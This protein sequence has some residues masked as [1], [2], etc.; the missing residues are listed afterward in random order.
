[1]VYASGKP[2]SRKKRGEHIVKPSNLLLAVTLAAVAGC[3]EPTI[4]ASTKEAIESSSQRVRDSLPETQQAEFDEAL[5]ILAFSE[6]DVND[7][8]AEG[9]VGSS[10]LEE[11]MRTALD[12]KTASEIIAEADKIVVE[13]KAREREQAM[14]EIKELHLK[15]Q[16]AET[17]RVELEKFEVFRSRFYMQKGDF[18]QNQPIIELSVRNGTDAPISRA[19]FEGTIASPER[20]VPWLKKEFNYSI[21]GGLEP[22]E[23]GTWNLAPNQFSEWGKVDAPTDAIFTVTVERLDGPGG[24]KLYSNSVFGDREQERLAELKKRY[25]VE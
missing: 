5:K 17:A 7:L 13:R 22:G 9:A 25:G 23:E 19:Y 24:E 2:P 20:S 10:A 1:M 6:V 21:S 18:G 16:E 14:N 4:D 12:G 11:K 8:L 3:S 15:Q